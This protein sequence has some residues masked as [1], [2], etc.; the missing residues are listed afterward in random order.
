ML[1]L[2]YFPKK[3]EYMLPLLLVAAALGVLF[4]LPVYAFWRLYKSIKNKDYANTKEFPQNK[5]ARFVYF[6]GYGSI[7]WNLLVIIIMFLIGAQLM[8]LDSQGIIADALTS[9]QAWFGLLA[10][11]LLLV[12]PYRRKHYW[13]RLLIVVLAFAQVYLFYAIPHFFIAQDER[14]QA[15]MFFD[16]LTEE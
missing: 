15:E 1:E 11:L 6:A 3:M 2:F 13:H 14:N 7:A 12:P 8:P 5:W 10:V 16:G 4:V 9:V